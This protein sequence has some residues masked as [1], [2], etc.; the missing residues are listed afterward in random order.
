MQG[1]SKIGV[2]L[3]AL[4][5]ALPSLPM[6]TPLH[7]EVLSAV[8]S[9]TKHLTD[10]GQDQQHLLMTLLQMARSAQQSQPMQ[11]LMKAFPGGA[12]GMGGPGGPPTLSGAGGP[13]T[14]GPMSMVH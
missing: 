6:G 2:A 1:M 14:P 13:P 5:E 4:Q 11:A 8:K 3:K 7:S 9:L 10:A 12:S